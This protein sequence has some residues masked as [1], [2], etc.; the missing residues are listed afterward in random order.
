MTEN[1]K[2]QTAKWES[3]RYTYRELLDGDDD[4]AT[5]AAAQA[6]MDATD[7]LRQVIREALA[8]GVKVAEAARITGWTTR[9][10]ARVR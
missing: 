5:E 8:Q 2:A 4:Y 7:A 1:L 6:Y 9:Q 10:I 3:A